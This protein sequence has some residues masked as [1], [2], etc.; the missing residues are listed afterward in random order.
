MSTIKR[1]T[2]WSGLFL[3]GFAIWAA[4]VRSFGG[5]EAWMTGLGTNLAIAGTYLLGYCFTNATLTSELVRKTELEAD[6]NAARQIQQT[7]IP[8]A[9][10]PVSGYA[11][12]T[13][14]RPFRQVGGDYF[15]VIPLAH[16]RTL[17]VIADV[18]GKGM[19][20][21]LLAANIQALVRSRAA[22]AI[23][24]V[25]VA[26]QIN[27]HVHA[28][29]PTER[30]ATAV[31]VLL[32]NATGDVIYVN[33]G[34]NA[35][36]IAGPGASAQLRA[37]GVPLGLF[38]ESSYSARSEQLPP[39]GSLLLYTDGL[40]DAIEGDAPEEAVRAAMRGT[41]EAMLGSLK[42]LIQTRL[43]ADDVTLVVVQRGGSAD[44]TNV[45]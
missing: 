6:Q 25:D 33:A 14:Y 18:A 36:M 8:Q 12:A 20:A 28:Y 7:L 42:K 32:E 30:Y 10:E 34:H 35:P 15:D 29:T 24:L 4:T 21:A 17:I 22:S 13:H 11:I 40:T 27:A 37:T 2:A 19:S 23:D 1:I 31:F 3:Q 5:P 43:S 26:Q 45:G 38:P 41:P 39:G 44:V 9:V 16:E